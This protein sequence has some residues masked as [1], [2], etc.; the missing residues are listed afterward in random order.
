MKDGRKIKDIDE[1][2]EVLKKLDDSVFSFHVNENKNDFANWIRDVFNYHGLA[3][4]IRHASKEDMIKILSGNEEPSK[5]PTHEKVNEPSGNDIKEEN[6]AKPSGPEDEEI[7]VNGKEEPTIEAD[8][9]LDEN[10]S[11]IRE[12]NKRVDGIDINNID[13]ALDR[14]NEIYKH[15]R[16]TKPSEIT[17]EDSISKSSST[18]SLQNEEKDNKPELEEREKKIEEKEQELKKKEEELERK[19]KKYDEEMKKIRDKVKNLI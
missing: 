12:I 8:D 17:M 10:Q 4:R 3:E 6:V 18:L 5:N 16:K 11:R 2:K 19:M 1:L 9:D 13:K 15:E 14:L 7:D